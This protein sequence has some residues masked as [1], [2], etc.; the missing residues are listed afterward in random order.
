MKAEIFIL[1]AGRGSRLPQLRAPKQLTPVAD[2]TILGRTLGLLTETAFAPVTLAIPK[3][4]HALRHAALV[5]RTVRVLEI[6][7]SG[8][9]GETIERAVE[10]SHT[11]DLIFLLGDVCWS[12]RALGLFLLAATEPRAVLYGRLGP[13]SATGKSHGEIFA[14]SAGRSWLRALPLGAVQRLWNFRAL[15][16]R[17]VEAPSDDWTDDIDT[18]DDL[19]RIV[20]RWNAFIGAQGKAA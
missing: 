15:G 8:S 18:A 17:M 11:E 4:N 12:R 13:S 16:A 19:E 14:L 5:S 2:S 6:E 1:C 9:I 3:G 20:P 7:A 10:T